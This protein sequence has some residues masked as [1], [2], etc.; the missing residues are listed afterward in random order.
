MELN[1]NAKNHLKSLM[2]CDAANTSREHFS[3]L[4]PIET[5]NKIIL[6]PNPVG[7]FERL[8]NFGII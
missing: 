4:D 5:L 3:P 1:R 7:A 8:Q 2:L 6:G